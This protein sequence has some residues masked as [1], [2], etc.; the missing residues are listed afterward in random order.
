MN[1]LVQLFEQ[2]GQAFWLDFIAR[3]FIADGSL[4]KMVAD[5][6]LRGVTSNPAIFE[7]AIADSE[8]YDA[9]FKSELEKSDCSIEALYERVVV[10]DIQN[11]C[12][13]LLP[14]YRSSK[15]TDGYVSLEVSPYLAKQAEQTV[16]EAKHLYPLVQ[17]ENL[18]IKVPATDDGIK[19]LKVLIAEGISVN[20]TLLFSADVYERV[21]IAYCEGLQLF[22]EKGGDVSKVASVAS[23]FISRIDQAIDPLLKKKIEASVDPKMKQSIQALLGKVAIANAKEAYA[24]FHRIFSGDQWKAL[25]AKGAQKQRLLWASTGTKN[26]DYSDVLYVEELI[27]QDTVNT[28]PV[29]TI[30]AFRDHGAVKAT[31]QEGIDEARDV[32]KAV[33]EIG[34]SLSSITDTLLE[35]GIAL[36]CQAADR[37]FAAI[38]RKRNAFL[39]ARSNSQSLMLMPKLSS[40]YDVALKQAKEHFYAQRIWEKDRLLWKSEDEQH[41]LGWLHSVQQEQAKLTAYRAFQEDVKAKQFRNA[42]LLGM[43]GSSL[44]PE[45][46]SEV[47]GTAEGFPEFIV[48][49]T[50]DP[51]TIAAVEERLDLK[52]TLFIVS[53]KSG[54]TTEPNM[55]CDYFFERV[56]AAGG[57]SEQFIAVTDPKSSLSN[58]ATAKKFWKVFYGNPEIGGRYSVLSPFGIVPAAVMGIDLE[59]LLTAAQTMV[60][61]CSASLSGEENPGLQLGLALGVAAQE[62]MDKITFYLSETLSPLSD[63]L[64]QLFAESTG[65]EGTGLVPVA[66]EPF[67]DLQHYGKD[68]FFVLVEDT[69]TSKEAPLEKRAKL[70]QKHGYSCVYIR[71]TRPEQLVQE[72]FRFSFAIAGASILLNVNPFNQPNVESAKLKTKSLFERYKKTGMIKMDQPLYS[73][74][75]CAVSCHSS[76]DQVSF[77]RTRSLKECF[78]EYLG[79]AQEGDYITFLLFMQ[80][81]KELDAGIEQ[82]RKH[83][84]E[85]RNLATA[86]G[87]GPRFLHSTGQLYKGGANRGLFV[88]IV[89]S[90]EGV[91]NLSVDQIPFHAVLSMQAAGDCEAMEDHGRRIV[92]VHLKGADHRK[93]VH[94]VFEAIQNALNA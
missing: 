56:H 14:L 68:R 73:D 3:E 48:L 19:A 79:S 55:L 57:N 60:W 4:A 89:A 82:I 63:W 47:I 24:R 92:T 20:V 93:A 41:W 39:G 33:E 70:L 28:M 36:F 38:A 34:I 15:G 44:G 45:V 5:D 85:K 32:L 10:E 42:V 54:G 50:T 59:A 62:G 64:E 6:G 72:F 58:K 30:Q 13:C 2:E 52:R 40:V 61:S 12:T 66:H 46:I 71:V 90:P 11:A 88:Q 80:R 67:C 25:A 16:Q 21:A 75:L 22:A 35:D 76:I 87:Y 27:G 7:K 8:Q 17:R 69:S 9:Q 81:T 84:V 23:F 77:F 86:Y 43:G 91:P 53:S 49:D 37:L 74:E 1:S 78:K 65:K 31:L 83:I 18:M 51:E 94:H 29:P 26:P